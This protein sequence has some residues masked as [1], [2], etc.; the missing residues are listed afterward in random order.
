MA[1]NQNA[2]KQPMER[3]TI[4]MCQ[5]E[6]APLTFRVLRD[7][8]TLR[9]EKAFHPLYAWTP[10]DWACAMAGEAGEVCNAVKKLRRHEDGTNT[11]LDPETSQACIN[12]IAQEA[13]DT[14][15]YLDLLCARLGIDLGEAVREKFNEV[16]DR[17]RRLSTVKL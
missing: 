16:S 10:M 3:A 17:T 9:C 5:S 13:A 6:P 14:V 7:A 1:I 15:I 12:A 2:N 8:N 4:D 11:V